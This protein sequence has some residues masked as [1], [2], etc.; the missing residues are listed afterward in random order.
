MLR[1][2][3]C[4]RW[5][6]SS[7]IPKINFTGSLNSHFKFHEYVVNDADSDM[8]LDRY[9]HLQTKL[10]TSTIQKKIRRNEVKLKPQV[11]ENGELGNSENRIKKTFSYK[12]RP[13]DVILIRSP[14]LYK[15]A[16]LVRPTRLAIKSFS[17]KEIESIRSMIVYIDDEIIVI[18]KPQGLATQG[19]PKSIKHVDGLLHA[20]Q[21]DYPDPPRLVHRLDKNTTGA[22]VLGR[23]RSAAGK[24]SHLFR[25]STIEKMYVAIVTKF[26]PRNLA[27]TE[28]NVPI[29]YGGKPPFEKVTC[30]LDQKSLLIENCK[31]AITYYQVIAGAGDYSLLRLYPKTGRKHQLRSHCAYVLKAPILGDDKYIL[32]K[33]DKTDTGSETSF[34]PMYLH[35]NRLIIHNWRTPEGKILTKPIEITAPLP[36]YFKKKSEEL[37]GIDAGSD[38]I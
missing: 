25:E 20:L 13:G 38:W 22:L 2:N 26:L 8:R 21:Y 34:K 19:G 23:T 10:P 24:L 36:S 17:E 14:D 4:S 33:I 7:L 35:L 31:S 18:N 27:R 5:F 30:I 28:I 32:D 3:F 9:L 1:Y 15:E 12:V 29:R 16:K 37:F 11:H 6:S